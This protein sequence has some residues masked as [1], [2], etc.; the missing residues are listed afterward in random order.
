MVLDAGLSILDSFLVLKA[1]RFLRSALYQ[2]TTN[3]VNRCGGTQ[4]LAVRGE[5][6]ESS[7]N[8]RVHSREM[9]MGGKFNTE[10]ADIY[11]VTRQRRSSDWMWPGRKITIAYPSRVWYNV[12]YGGFGSWRFQLLTAFQMFF[13]PILG[14]PRQYMTCPP[15][16]ARLP[17]FAV[18]FRRRQD[19]EKYWVDFSTSERIC[20]I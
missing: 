8:K 3:R 14:F 7:G 13:R 12:F 15:I 9:A 2:L 17:S 1:V 10:F 18:D 16:N 6:V 5:V 19:E 11:A 20:W 4:T